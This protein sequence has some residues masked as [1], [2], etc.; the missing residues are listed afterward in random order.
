MKHKALEAAIAL[1]DASGLH[2]QRE[3]YRYKDH[4]DSFGKS[5]QTQIRIL[6]WTDEDIEVLLDEWFVTGDSDKQAETIVKICNQ[7]NGVL[8]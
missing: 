2:L 1:V 3:H 5:G 8:S 6:Y 7:F 4:Y